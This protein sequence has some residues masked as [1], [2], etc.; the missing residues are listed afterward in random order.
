MCHGGLYNERGGDEDW[1][2]S[3]LNRQADKLW[4]FFWDRLGSSANSFLS[5]TEPW[6]AGVPYAL[7]GHDPSKS[8]IYRIVMR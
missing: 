2:L 6:P 3:V 4:T 5:P 8:R 1:R 7:D